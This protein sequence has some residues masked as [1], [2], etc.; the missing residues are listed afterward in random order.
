MYGDTTVK[1]RQQSDDAVG[2]G[3]SFVMRGGDENELL[4][5][6]RKC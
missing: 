2:V 1:E 3:T 4:S 5:P 6:C